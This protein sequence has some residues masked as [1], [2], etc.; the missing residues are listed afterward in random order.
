MRGKILFLGYN[1]FDYEKIIC[2]AI[3]N[4]LKKEVVYI[5]ALEEEYSYKNNREKIFNNLVY[6]PFFRKNL[7]DEKFTKRIIEKIEKI[8]DIETIFCIRPDKLNHDIM[9]YLKSKGI[10]MIVHHWDSISF[11]KKQE[12][13]LK[14]FDVKS[15]FDKKEAEKYNMK[16]VPNFYIKEN[17]VES[18]EKKYDFFTVMKLDKRVEKL[19]KLARKLREKGKK[20]LFIVV[21]EE[22]KGYKSEELIVVDKKITLEENYRYISESEGIVEIGHEKDEEGRYQGGLSFRIFDAIGNKKKIITNYSFIDEYD[23]YN[24]KNIFIIKDDNYQLDDRFLNAA[25]EELEPELYEKYSDEQWV[26]EI[27]DVKKN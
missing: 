19:E 23:F 2:N 10:K 3:K 22:G 17:I 21:D 15:T 9:K 13:Y 4:T 18:K 16:F 26:K 12:E 7:K 25:Y 8:K 1:F 5:N 27:F 14:Y 11:I 20:Y 6:K 24:R